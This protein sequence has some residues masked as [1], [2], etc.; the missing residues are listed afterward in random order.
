[1]GGMGPGGGGLEGGGRKC[2]P[3][4]ENLVI[5]LTIGLNIRTIVS[6]RYCIDFRYN[7]GQPGH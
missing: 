4:E 6:N 7:T 3:P 1:M 5:I 2:I